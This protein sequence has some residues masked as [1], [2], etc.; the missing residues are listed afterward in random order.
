MEEK[1]AE[2]DS[3]EEES[4]LIIED[5]K[6]PGHRAPSRLDLR[7]LGARDCPPEVT[8]ARE[9]A[10]RR[11]GRFLSTRLTGYPLTWECG[12]GHKWRATLTAVKEEGHWCDVCDVRG[13]RG[14]ERCRRILEELM[15]V[16]FPKSHPEFLRREETGRCLELDGYNVDLGLAFEHQGRQHYHHVP[17]W[18]TEQRGL[19]E[20]QERDREKA[21]RCLAQRVALLVVPYYANGQYGAYIRRRLEEMGYLVAAPSDEK[22]VTDLLP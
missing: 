16:P 4:E 6:L 8:A 1:S 13:S 11:G 18:H 2:E 12:G 3:S 7:P 19:A 21:E 5:V 17:G 22:N 10:A 9:L 15:G 20:Q 14:E